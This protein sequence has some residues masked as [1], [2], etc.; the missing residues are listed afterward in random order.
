MSW[1]DALPTVRGRLRRDVPL[2]KLTWLRVGGPAA[3]LFQPADADDLATLRAALPAEVPI[4]ALGVGSNLLV[5]DGGFDGVVIRLAGRLGEVRVDDEIVIAGGGALDRHV[6]IAA[7]R[8][9]VGGL[10]FLSGIPG[11]MGGAVRMNAGCFGG[12][13]A[14]VFV[15]ASALDGS[16]ERHGLTAA[17]LGFGYRHSELSED[18]IVTEVRL[19]GRQGDPKEIDAR[20]A[21][22]RAQREA[23]QPLRVA[24]GGST[25]RNPPGHKA[26]QLI[27]AAGCRGLRRGAAVVSE[28]H[29]N[30]LINEGGATADDL[31]GLG[32]DV[33]A[34]VRD[35]A[36]IEL[37]WEI[38]RVGTAPRAVE[39]AA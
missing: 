35:H 25:F 15:S 2:A 23:T 38:V 18:W 37:V 14:E 28:K 27:D 9:G 22:I 21:E 16:G 19:R 24:T 12:E 1:R 17:E 4:L 39:A 26:W 8:A 30:F 20:L 5:R 29:C 13:L 36:G 11:T 31:E 32:E 33:R 6:A 7:A 3:V 10:E 34:R